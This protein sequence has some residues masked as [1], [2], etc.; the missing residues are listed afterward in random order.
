VVSPSCPFI[1]KGPLFLLAFVLVGAGSAKACGGWADIACNVGKAV[2]KGAQDTGKTIEKAGQDTGKTVE[3]AGQDTGKAVEKGVHDVGKTVEK[4]VQDTGHTLEKAAHDTGHT[5]EKAGQDVGHFFKEAINFNLSCSLPGNKPENIAVSY[6][7]ACGSTFSTYQHDIDV[8]NQAGGASLL[9]AGT[10]A[11][12]GAWTGYGAATYALAKLAFEL[13]QSACRSQANLKTCIGDVD[14]AARGKVQQAQASASRNDEDVA[15]QEL[16]ACID[17]AY[18]GEKL[19]IM[20]QIYSKCSASKS[21]NT[22]DPSYTSTFQAQ[23]NKEA[24]D[25]DARRKI[26]LDALKKG[27]G[28]PVL[29]YGPTIKSPKLSAVSITAGE[30]DL[31]R[32][33]RARRPELAARLLVRPAQ[34]KTIKAIWTQGGKTIFDTPVIP[35]ATG[36]ALIIVNLAN[37]PQGRWKLQVSTDTGEALGEFSFIYRPETP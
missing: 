35:D 28:L 25:I 7:N 2:E 23:V 22:Q 21:C 13:C 31:T 15:R 29:D 6:R 33:C 24:Q 19:T 12:F 8:C 11:A 34:V 14:K 16:F 27:E 37:Q 3:K 10:A 18:A 20:D 9:A 36:Q 30:H 4:A 5:L 17:D 32:I 26:T 1:L